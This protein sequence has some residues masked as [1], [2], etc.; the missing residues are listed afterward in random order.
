MGFFQ[1]GWLF[2]IE[3]FAADHKH[4]DWEL[5]FSCNPALGSGIQLIRS[6]DN[7][8]A[9]PV[10]IRS[11]FLCQSPDDVKQKGLHDFQHPD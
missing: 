4:N 7:H 1:T 5:T 2:V 11:R 9:H 6:A 10:K 3:C 8:C